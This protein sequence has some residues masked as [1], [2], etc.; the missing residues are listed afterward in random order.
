VLKFATVRFSRWAR[1]PRSASSRFRYEAKDLKRSG[2]AI[3]LVNGTM[4]V[5]N[6]RHR[7][8]QPP[9]CEHHGGSIGGDHRQERGRGFH[10]GCRYRAQEVAWRQ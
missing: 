4:R 7:G 2:V 1:P 9:G 10:P 8:R 6:R 5:I 3:A